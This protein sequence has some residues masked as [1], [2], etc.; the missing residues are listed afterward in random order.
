M[1]EK[2]Q[3]DRVIVVAVDSYLD[4]MT[5]EWLSETERLNADENG[6][7]LIPGEA[8]ACF[9]LESVSSSERRHAR[10][11]ARVPE[12]LG[13]EQDHLCSE[14]RNQGIALGSVISEA[15][16]G[17]SK[18]ERFDGVVISDF[19]GETWRALE[20]GGARVRAL[21][22]LGSDPHFL[23]PSIS[24]GE[25]GAASGACAVCF[26]ARFLQRPRSR[27]SSALILSSSESGEVGAVCLCKVE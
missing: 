5:L 13:F 1:I 8:G 19:N 18:F 15:L 27:Y 7:G 20:L 2:G 24:V 12:A 23:F 3:V 26:A 6:K 21:A 9:M 25:V 4:P 11:E 17:A 22:E 10:I 16:R 14:K